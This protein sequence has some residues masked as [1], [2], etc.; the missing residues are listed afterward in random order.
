MKIAANLSLLFS[1]YPL[2][3]RIDEACASGFAGVEIQFPY[4]IAA[5]RL[6]E[7]LERASLPLVLINLPAGD[8]MEGGPG[9]ACIP[10]RQDEFRQALRDALS[11][12]AMVRPQCVNVLAGRLIEG[13][14][15]EQ[16][17]QTLA[18]NLRRA[19]REFEL[20]GI[21][22]LCEAINPLDMPRFLINTPDDLLEILERV[23]HPNCLAQ[24]DLYHLARQEL[25]IAASIQRLGKRIGHVQFADCPG[26]GA[27]GSG[28][29]DFPRALQALRDID[30]QGWLGAEYWPGLDSTR[31][32]LGWL[33]DWR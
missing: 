17:M 18:D 30:Y 3:E 29:M 8:L 15:R 25:D 11:Y 5:I 32:S 4:E 16:A 2:L 21:P 23:D 24:L 22:V 7:A 10:Q 27:P 1:E 31:Q 12:A 9:L 13:V 19:A 28:E 6:K 26:R 33:E 14:D 20:L